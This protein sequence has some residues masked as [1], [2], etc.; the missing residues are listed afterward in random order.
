MLGFGALNIEHAV[1]LCVCH[2]SKQRTITRL[3]IDPNS[4][5]RIEYFSSKNCILFFTNN[6]IVWLWGG[7]AIRNIQNWYQIDSVLSIQCGAIYWTEN[8]S[9][10]SKS[11]TESCF[12]AVNGFEPDTKH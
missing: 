9:N 7:Q 5:F 2:I 11:L 1:H 6:M 8:N 4:E 12:I 3:R 10:N